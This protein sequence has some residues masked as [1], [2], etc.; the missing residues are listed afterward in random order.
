MSIILSKN[1]ARDVPCSVL[2]LYHVLLTRTVLIGCLVYTPLLLSVLRWSAS[3]AV[4]NIVTSTQ[5]K[6]AEHEG[7][8][9]RN[10]LHPTI[11]LEVH[12]L[13][14]VISTSNSAPVF[15]LKLQYSL[16]KLGNGG[17]H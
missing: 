10:V 8:V 7:G 9:A 12:K 2:Y 11:L 1:P 15:A 5:G 3:R 16:A 14:Y 17:L 4:V 13:V 6:C